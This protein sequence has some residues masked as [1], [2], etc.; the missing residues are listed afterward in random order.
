MEHE[1]Q[2]GARR[3]S[4]TRK[5][6]TCCPRCWEPLVF[7]TH[8]WCTACFWEQWNTMLSQAGSVEDVQRGIEGM[9]G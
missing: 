9:R 8:W 4:K 3:M 5:T 2:M 1:A 7:T 6:T